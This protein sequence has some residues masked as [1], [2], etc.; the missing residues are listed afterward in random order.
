MKECIAIILTILVAAWFWVAWWQ[1]LQIYVAE[2]NAITATLETRE[3]T[4]V[5]VFP[6]SVGCYTYNARDEHR[7]IT[8]KVCLGEDSDG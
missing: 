6:K 2:K 3:L 1:Q 7:I 5:K 8:G 4:H